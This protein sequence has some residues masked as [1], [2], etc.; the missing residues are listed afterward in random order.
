LPT[1]S[2][3]AQYVGADAANPCRKYH[4]SSA[5][6]GAELVAGCVLPYLAQQRI[7]HKV[8]QSRRLLVQQTFKGEVTFGDQ[9]G[10]FITVYMPA[11][12]EQ[13]NNI[14]RHIGGELSKLA[15]T[16]AIEPCPRI[17]RSRVYRGVF[18]EQP[19][20]EDFF[21]YGGFI[22]DPFK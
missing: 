16:R 20:D 2:I 8:V 7:P 6:G 18:A 14:I 4:I 10:K 11:N 21:I 19:L 17:P 12:V 1:S 22:C 5:I 13:R 9:A 15:K 3:Y